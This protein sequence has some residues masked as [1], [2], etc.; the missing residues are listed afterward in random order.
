[1]RLVARF[2]QGLLLALALTLF[3]VALAHIFHLH[4]LPI[5]L[6]HLLLTVALGAQQVTLKLSS[7]SSLR[8]LPE[9]GTVGHARRSRAALRSAILALE[10]RLGA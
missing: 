9:D 4:G 5:A 6:R 2:E 3:V 1:M 10:Q 8:R 7:A